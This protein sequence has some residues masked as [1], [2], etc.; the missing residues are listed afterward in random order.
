MRE[1]VSRCLPAP[2]VLLPSE[3]RTLSPSVCPSPPVAPNA[4]RNLPG[5]PDRGVS[6]SCESV[7]SCLSSAPRRQ[8]LRFAMGTTALQTS[9]NLSPTVSLS[10]PADSH[11]AQNNLSPERGEG[12]WSAHTRPHGS[13][14]CESVS[15]CL[16]GITGRIAACRGSSAFT[17]T[18]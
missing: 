7:S 3:A 18:S 1:S 10:A 6:E 12:L 14:Q 13:G 4:P 17:S 9:L 2:A 11:M 5:A 16:S 15:F 8:I